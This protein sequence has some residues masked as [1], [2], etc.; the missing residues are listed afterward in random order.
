M[1]YVSPIEMTEETLQYYAKLFGLRRAVLVSDPNE[2]GNVTSRYKIVIPEAIDHFTMHNMALSTLL[3]YSPVALNR[4]KNLIRGRQAY[5]VPGVMNDD[6][7]FVADELKV[8]VLGKQN[9]TNTF[10]YNVQ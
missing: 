5:L 6:D 10:K 7:L 1:I 8:P 9:K 3:K 2:H 4:I